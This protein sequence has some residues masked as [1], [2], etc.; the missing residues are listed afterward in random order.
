MSPKHSVSTWSGVSAAVLFAGLLSLRSSTF[1]QRPVPRVG[2]DQPSAADRTEGGDSGGRT[3]S[4]GRTTP[5]GGQTSSGDQTSAGGSRTAVRRA[6]SSGDT[7]T[8]SDVSNRT[9]AR[10]ERGSSGDSGTSTATAGDNSGSV[11]P[12]SR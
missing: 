4:A 2:S 9:P 7:N 12:Y 10:R 6:P 8:T 5:S 3:A 1:A 11:P